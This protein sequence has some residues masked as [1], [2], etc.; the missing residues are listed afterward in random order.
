MRAPCAQPWW[1]RLDPPSPVRASPERVPLWKLQLHQLLNCDFS[2]PASW[3]SIVKGVVESGVWKHLHIEDFPITVFRA[4]KQTVDFVQLVIEVAHFAGP[5]DV[6]ANFSV[7]AWRATVR[8]GRVIFGPTGGPT[9]KIA[10][11]WLEP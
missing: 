11:E 1:T 5:P 4:P 7:G 2:C 8:M 10:T 3:Q 9:P 6:T